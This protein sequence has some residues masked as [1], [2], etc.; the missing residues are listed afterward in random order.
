MWQTW[1]WGIM[2]ILGGIA[3]IFISFWMALH[4]NNF[5]SK[6]LCY[7]AGFLSIY[8][9]GWLVTLAVQKATRT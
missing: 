6:V 1:V 3:L 4:A 2:G 7:T 5:I 8:M 9:T